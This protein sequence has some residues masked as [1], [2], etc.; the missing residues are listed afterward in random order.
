MAAGDA[1]TETTV[2]F[3]LYAQMRN[4]PMPV[5]LTAPIQQLGISESRGEISFD[6]DAPL[7]AIRRSITAARASKAD[8][9]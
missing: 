8:E 3:D 7:A 4:D 9:K 6:D 2:M 1:A 5:D